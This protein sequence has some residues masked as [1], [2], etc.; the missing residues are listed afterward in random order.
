MPLVI[1]TYN[2]VYSRHLYPLQ[3]RC[4]NPFI[5]PHAFAILEQKQSIRAGQPMR[6]V[7]V[8]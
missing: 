4:E 8:R 3:L 7:F 1:I 2:I 5:F 6:T